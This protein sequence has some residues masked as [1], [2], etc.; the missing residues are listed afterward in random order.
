M[1][2]LMTRLRRSKRGATALEYGLLGALIAVAA[3]GAIQRSSGELKGIFNRLLVDIRAANT[4]R[5]T[6][7]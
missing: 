4:N 2:H 1:K 7:A 5:S 3:M 6:N